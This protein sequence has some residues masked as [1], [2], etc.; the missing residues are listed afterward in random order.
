MTTRSPRLLSNRPNEA[1][2]IPLP[3]DDT[4]P[5]V[6][7][8]C[9]A[10]YLSSPVA[11]GSGRGGTRGPAP[12]LVYQA[13]RRPVPQRTSVRDRTRVPRRPAHHTAEF[14]HSS[15]FI[16]CLQAC[17]GSICGRLFAY[18]VVTIGE[19]GHLRQ[20]GDHDHLALR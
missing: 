6:T 16:E 9:F 13:R 12:H 17:H 7:N 5:P 15:G 2:V 11:V 18:H 1:A 20:M 3:R 10:M 4:T 14:L 19:G 8:T